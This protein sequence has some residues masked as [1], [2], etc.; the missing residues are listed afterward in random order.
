[1]FSMKQQG[2]SSG[3]GCFVRLINSFY[4]QGIFDFSMVKKEKNLPTSTRLV[5]LYQSYTEYLTA[6]YPNAGTVGFFLNGLLCLLRYMEKSGLSSLTD[7]AVAD[8]VNYI[9][10]WSQKHQGNVLCALRNIFQYFECDDLC[11][12]VKRIH[13]YRAKR[14][15]PMFT[16]DEVANIKETLLS[17][18]VSRRDAAIFLL[19][20]VT[21]MR[22]V[23]VVNLRLSTIN[24]SNE[25][26]VNDIKFHT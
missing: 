16:D 5:E 8:V 9:C 20:F 7:L 13:L 17:P 12:A 21:G 26:I 6:Q 19:G 2:N 24:W 25:T 15:V 22:A 1:M 11:F 4:L 18:Y 3:N 23:D 10:S 14:I